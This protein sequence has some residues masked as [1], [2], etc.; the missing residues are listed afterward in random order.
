MFCQYYYF[1]NNKRS[2]S[3]ENG[4]HIFVTVSKE[5]MKTLRI[6]HR[7]TVLNCIQ[8]TAISTLLVNKV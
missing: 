5:V 1:L 4:C 6:G 8:S 2:W 3:P 7:P